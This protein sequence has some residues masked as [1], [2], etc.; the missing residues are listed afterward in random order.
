MEGGVLSE[1]RG[2]AG[3]GGAW[4]GGKGWPGQGSMVGGRGSAGEEEGVEVGGWGKG[5]D[6]L[7]G[8]WR[9]RCWQRGERGSGG[10]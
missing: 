2:G 9:G 8:L 5:E 6:G 1:G 7:E 4:R 10:G 3:R